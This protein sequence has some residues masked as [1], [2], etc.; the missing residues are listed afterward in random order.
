MPAMA[1]FCYSLTMKLIKTKKF[2]ISSAVV[3][4]AVIGM[5]TIPVK[6]HGTLCGNGERFSMLFGQKDDYDASVKKTE[7]MQN[8]N[9]ENSINEWYGC[10]GGV[11]E[12][13]PFWEN[14]WH[15]LNSLDRLYII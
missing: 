11:Y 14:W 5:A 10:G 15:D 9:E 2:L 7:H 4:L 3:I 13:G 6:S 8:A 1:S 12:E